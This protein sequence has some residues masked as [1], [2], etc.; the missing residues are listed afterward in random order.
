[1]ILACMLRLSMSG[2]EAKGGKT[3]GSSRSGV[4]LGS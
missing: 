2:L 3:G 1:M 4:L